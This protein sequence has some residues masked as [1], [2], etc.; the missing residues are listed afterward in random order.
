MASVDNAS[1]LLVDIA[2]IHSF[3]QAQLA[4]L[5]PVCSDAVESQHLQLIAKIASINGL[6]VSI[7]TELTLK[8]NEGP[9]SPHQKSGI[10]SALNDRLGAVALCTT[11]KCR[12]LQK[13]ATMNEYLS[14]EDVAVLVDTGSHLHT[15]ITRVVERCW[16][17]GLELPDEQTLR[18]VVAVLVAVGLPDIQ[19]DPISMFN[20]L[21][22]FKHQLKLTSKCNHLPKG[23]DHIVSYPST[24]RQL[25][26]ALFQHC[27]TCATD[28]LSDKPC[29]IMPSYW[30]QCAQE[31]S[32]MPAGGCR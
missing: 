16:R 28:T 18:H 13:L 4:V 21:A 8:V 10:V 24:P 7:A 9:W 6:S 19:N 12:P 29:A 26:V 14:K 27:S 20:V 31:P 30:S 3:L 23:M 11:Q 5:G 22:E 1:K 15:K 32:S 25:P 17:L 2:H